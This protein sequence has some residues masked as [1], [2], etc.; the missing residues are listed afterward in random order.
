MTVV[1]TAVDSG[2]GDAVGDG[3][4]AT[5]IDEPA[6]AAATVLLSSDLRCPAATTAPMPRTGTA[7]KAHKG[8]LTD[9]PFGARPGCPGTT[10]ADSAGWPLGGGNALL[11]E[12]RQKVPNGSQVQ[13]DLYRCRRRPME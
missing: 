9:L 1:G 3:A 4:A 11:M 8:T 12:T 10:D 6:V 13:L 5:G 2:V 7:I